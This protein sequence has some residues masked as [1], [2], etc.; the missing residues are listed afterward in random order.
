MTIHDVRAALLTSRGDT[1]A[2]YQ[3]VWHPV[4]KLPADAQAEAARIAVP[5]DK[6]PKLN[7]KAAPAQ[8]PAESPA[9][10]IKPD[11]VGQLSLWGAA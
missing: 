4:E 6:A 3:G 2:L 11:A 7:L 5:V 1:L 9:P 8:P 10:E